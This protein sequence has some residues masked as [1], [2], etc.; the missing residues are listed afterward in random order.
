LAALQE[1]EWLPLL[2]W[3]RATINLDLATTKGINAVPQDPRTLNNFRGWLGSMDNFQL[4]GLYQGITLLGSVVAG[5]ALQSDVISPQKAM[6][7]CFLDEIWQESR[8]GL[9]DEAAARR[10]A[11]NRELD[12]IYAFM[13][14]FDSLAGA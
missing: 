2:D 8:W 6:E 3:A 11:L 4:A 12:S 9:D 13:R 14:S 10:K 5:L 1:R 7:L